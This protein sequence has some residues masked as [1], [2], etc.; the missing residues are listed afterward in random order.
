MGNDRETA[1]E[2]PDCGGPLGGVYAEANYGR[3]LLLDQCRSC[4]G[5]W[6]DRWELYFLKDSSLGPLGRFDAGSFKSVT[7]DGGAAHARPAVTA[8]WSSGTRPSRRIQP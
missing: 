2:C 7:R 8:S 1:R 3:V 5:V 4:G 6:F